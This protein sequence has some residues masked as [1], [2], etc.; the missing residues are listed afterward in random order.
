MVL[1]LSLTRIK[2]SEGLKSSEISTADSL[3]QRRSDRP[4]FKVLMHETTE[5][6][7]NEDVRTVSSRIGDDRTRK[8]NQSQHICGLQRNEPTDSFISVEPNPI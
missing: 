6:F 8:Q 7:V 5:R 2:Y 4:A 1:L 3:F